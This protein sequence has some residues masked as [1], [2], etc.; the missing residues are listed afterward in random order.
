M[1]EHNNKTHSIFL[2]QTLSANNLRKK[3]IKIIFSLVLTRASLLAQLIKNLPA[4][5]ETWIRFLDWE[6]L[7]E[8]GMQT[9]TGILAWRFPM[10][11]G[12]WWAAVHWVAN[13]QTGLSD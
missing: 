2:F 4:M 1:T 8:E 11:R 10:D 7:L 13:S 5:W 12:A 6:D 3:K 9:H